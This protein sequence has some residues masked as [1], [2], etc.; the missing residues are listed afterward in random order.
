[1]G[2]NARF[3]ADWMHSFKSV[4]PQLLDANIRVLVYAGEMDY[5]CNYMGNKAW[6]LALEWTGKPQFN[7]AGDHQWMVEG[8][9]AGLARSAQGL[10]FLQVF[11]AGHM[12]PLDQPRN[13]LA[14]VQAFL[15]D[16]PFY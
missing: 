16:A 13:S 5:I 9:A 2:V 7:D 8:E 15:D 14:M 11:G 12:V 4:I 10:T 1:M 3:R 6:T